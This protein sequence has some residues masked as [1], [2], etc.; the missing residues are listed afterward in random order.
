MKEDYYIILM[1]QN[2]T[3]GRNM[4]SIQALQIYKLKDKKNEANPKSQ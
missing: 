2:T 3:F 1:D 4:C